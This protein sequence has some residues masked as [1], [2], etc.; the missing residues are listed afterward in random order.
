MA[1]YQAVEWFRAWHG[2]ATDPKWILVAKAANSGVTGRDVTLPNVTS[3]T[4]GH[5]SAIWL[6]LCERASQSRPRGSIAGFN[7]EV[8]A[9]CYGWDVELIDAV[10]RALKAKGLIQGDKLAS[11]NDR[12]PLKIDRTAKE[13]KRRQRKAERPETVLPEQH[14]SASNVTP[15]H[16]VTTRDAVTSRC[17]TTEREID[18][19]LSRSTSSQDSNN[20]TPYNHHDARASVG[21]IWR[22][23]ES[24]GVP[25]GIVARTRNAKRIAGWIEAGMTRGQLDGAITRARQARKDQGDPAPINI[26]FIDSCLTQSQKGGRSHGFERGDASVDA[27]VAGRS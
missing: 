19:S 12:N 15:G 8:L 24:E 25:V 11:W 7:A 2:M 23:L 10:V 16:G 5:V 6:A 27:Y 3:V 22:R 17:V 18:I 20:S 9:A 1:G 14:S 26:G 21:E 13:R 4:P